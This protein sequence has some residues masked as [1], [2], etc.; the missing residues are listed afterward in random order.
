[1]YCYSEPAFSKW[2]WITVLLSRMYILLCLVKVF[3][4]YI[5][6]ALSL[7][8]LLKSSVNYYFV[9]WIL[10]TKQCCSE[11]WFVNLWLMNIFFFTNQVA[12]ITLA[13]CLPG[14]MINISIWS[15]YAYVSMWFLNICLSLF[16]SVRH[17]A[18]AP[19]DLLFWCSCG[20]S[21]PPTRHRVIFSVLLMAA[22]SLALLDYPCEPIMPPPSEHS[23][24]LSA[25]YLQ[26]LPEPLSP[27]SWSLQAQSSDVA[28][29]KSDVS[30]NKISIALVQ[31]LICVWNKLGLMEWRLFHS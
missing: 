8:E 7:P 24:L 17:F 10:S 21:C 20:D 31:V 5:T 6:P 3:L 18:I 15:I 13:N 16:L 11:V 30:G 4:G 28:S 22:G 25:Y 26:C 14:K 23:P 12:Y 2:G 29:K 19:V 27:F 9:K 1:M